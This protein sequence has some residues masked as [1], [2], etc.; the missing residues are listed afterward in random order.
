[1]LNEQPITSYTICKL[2]IIL[3]LQTD[4]IYIYTRECWRG[5]NNQIFDIEQKQ[6]FRVFELE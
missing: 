1:M 2:S 6:A 3:T 5:K 4:S